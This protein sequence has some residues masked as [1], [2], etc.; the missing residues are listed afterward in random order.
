MPVHFYLSMIPE[1]LV[2]SMLDPAEFGTYLATGTRKRTRDQA[3]FFA[4]KDGFTSESFDVAGA[5]GRCV[6][7]AD[8]SPKHSVY[9][10]VYRVLERVPLDA[11]GN[12][13]LTTRDGRNLQLAQGTPPEN[14]GHTFHLYREIC[15]LQPLIAATLETAEFCRFITD[16][17][18]PISVPRICFVDLDLAGLAE[19]PAHGDAADLPYPRIDHLRD[20]LLQLRKEGEKPTKTVDRI[21]AHQFPFRCIR[22]GFYVGDQQAMLYYP[23][24]SHEVLDRD[25]HDWWRSAN[26]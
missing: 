14:F 24:P 3:L 7:H 11:L 4:L 10:S 17:T 19:D 13:W 15:P 23:F 8:G 18:H 2:A 5:V 6:A 9:L 12:L 25:H 22:S 16:P 21:P 26:V 1:S 20:C